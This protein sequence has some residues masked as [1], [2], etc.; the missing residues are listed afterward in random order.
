MAQPASFDWLA[1][2][3]NRPWTAQLAM[4]L[5]PGNNG[6]KIE[7]FRGSVVVTPHAGFDHQAIE[8]ELA[9]PLHRAARR[10]GLWCYAELVEAE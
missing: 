2:V 6:P 5:L 8:R 1:K 3:N 4:E 7:V 9:Y 10:A